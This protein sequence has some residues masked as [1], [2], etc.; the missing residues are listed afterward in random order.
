M[1]DQLDNK[2]INKAWHPD[3]G[4]ICYEVQELKEAKG[5][6]AKPG[7]VYWS[8]LTAEPFAYKDK[9]QEFLVKYLK[10]K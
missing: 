7:D 4:C 5:K 2:R 10:N 9:A 1:L 3:G 6:Y 8:N